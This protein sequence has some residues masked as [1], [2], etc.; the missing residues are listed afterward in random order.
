MS[1]AFLLAVSKDTLKDACEEV[2]FW[3]IQLYTAMERA[4]LACW[5][6][7]GHQRLDDLPRRFYRT[8]LN[9]YL[10]HWADGSP[11]G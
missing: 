9:V 4:E 6:N 8:G 1:N 5:I 11:V 10:M 3:H 2:Q 7:P